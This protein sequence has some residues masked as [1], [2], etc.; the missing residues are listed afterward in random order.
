MINQL[1]WPLLETRRKIARLTLMYKMANN[2]VLM[3]YRSLLVRYPY[4]T[5]DMPPHAYVPMDKHPQKL[6]YEATF[7]PQ[8]IRDWNRLDESV[9]DAGPLPEDFK[10]SVRMVL[11]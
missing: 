6:Y 1:G 3:T 8:T 11:P 4:N 10:S 7:F 5:K 2:F 9:A